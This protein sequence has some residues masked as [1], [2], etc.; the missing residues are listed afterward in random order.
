MTVHFRLFEKGDYERVLKIC[1]DAFTPHHSLFAK[2]LG[3]EI[4]RY[5]YQDWREQYADYLRQFPDT[6]T[7]AKAYVAEQG[8]EVVGFIITTLDEKRKVGEIGL[9]AVDPAHQV[10]G[11]GKA[12][13]AFA[14]EDFRKRGAKVAY[15][16]TGADWAHGLA[17]YSLSFTRP[18]NDRCVPVLCPK[19]KRFS[20][21]QGAV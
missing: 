18:V 16:S 11:I 19:G 5:Q 12:M 21:R 14:L 4:F 15:V 10:K 13:Y 9:N 17:R 1:I 20:S 7:V 3:S 6:D 2:T 8:R